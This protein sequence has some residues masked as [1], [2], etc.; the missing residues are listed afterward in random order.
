MLKM[1]SADFDINPEIFSW[2]F[3]KKIESSVISKLKGRCFPGFIS[4][5]PSQAPVRKFDFLTEIV[6]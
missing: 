4:S 5:F 3:T 1:L 6:S 2:P